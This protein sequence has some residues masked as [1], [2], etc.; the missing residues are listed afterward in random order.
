MKTS[1]YT[2][3]Q[4]KK[5]QEKNI[6]VFLKTRIKEQWRIEADIFVGWIDL[7]LIKYMDRT[8]YLLKSVD[9]LSTATP[10]HEALRANS[11]FLKFRNLLTHFQ[12]T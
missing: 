9:S 6:L 7:I 1:F 2:I 8:P 11:L 4:G 3:P 10:T 12:M 5:K